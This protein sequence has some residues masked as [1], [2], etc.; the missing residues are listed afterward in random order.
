MK[1]DYCALVITILKNLC[2]NRTGGYKAK[3]RINPL[4]FWGGDPKFVCDEVQ[5]D[6]IWRAV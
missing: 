4:R 1:D 3:E 5:S 2:F 6:Q